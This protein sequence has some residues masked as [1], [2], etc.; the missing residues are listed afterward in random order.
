MTAFNS[1]YSRNH[2]VGKENEGLVIRLRA[3]TYDEKNS[4]LD[5]DITLQNNVIIEPDKTDGTTYDEVTLELGG[6]WKEDK[7]SNVRLMEFSH[8][9]SLTIGGKEED[10]NKA[11][12]DKSKN[13][14]IGTQSVYGKKETGVLSF[15]DIGTLTIN[16]T[17]KAQDGATVRIINC[18]D[19][20]SNKHLSVVGGTFIFDNSN[21]TLAGSH[22]DRSPG[23]KNGAI[24]TENKDSGA[25]NI[26]VRN[27]TFVVEGTSTATDPGLYVNLKTDAEFMITG[28]CT[29]NGV[30]TNANESG[31]NSKT[32]I[33]F[34]NATLDENTK[35]L[36]GDPSQG[37]AALKF[38][39]YNTLDG[40]TVAQTGNRNMTVEAGATV[41]MTNEASISVGGSVNVQNC[42]NISLDNNSSISAGS[43]DNTGSL[44]LSDGATIKLGDM[45]TVRDAETPDS[46]GYLDLTVA[47]SESYRNIT[48]VV[49]AAET[50]TVGNVT[51]QVGQLLYS[52][53]V[54][55]VADTTQPTKTKTVSAADLKKFVGKEV[56]VSIG[57]GTIPAEDRAQMG[58]FTNQVNGV[59]TVDLQGDGGI[60]VTAGGI[61]NYG[62]IQIDLSHTDYPPE[63]LTININGLNNSDGGT[64]TVIGGGGTVVPRS[65]GTQYIQLNV[66]QMQ[67]LYVNGT[68]DWDP[69]NAWNKGK[70]VGSRM[71]YGFNSFKDNPEATDDY[72][73]MTFAG[74][75]DKV[76]YFGG[77]QYNDFSIP[78]DIVRTIKVDTTTYTRCTEKDSGTDYYAWV[79]G[80]AV[81]YTTTL[82]ESDFN[83]ADDNDE[84]AYWNF[85]SIA[86]AGDY[87]Y[88]SGTIM[89]E[90]KTYSRNADKDITVW[91]CCAWQQD[92]GTAVVYTKTETPEGQ[93]YAYT[94]NIEDTN[95]S[96]SSHTNLNSLTLTTLAGTAIIVKPGDAAPVHYIRETAG[97]MK[98]VT[99]NGSVQYYAWK[100][101]TDS[102][103][104]TETLNI[105]TGSSDT[106]FYNYQEVQTPEETIVYYSVVA[107]TPE[108]TVGENVYIRD[109]ADDYQ[110]VR[111]GSTVSYYA[112]KKN[113]DVVYTD[114]ISIK[115]ENDEGSHSYKLYSS[116][117]SF[118][119]DDDD[120]DDST[121]RTI[122]LAGDTARMGALTVGG[123]Q[124]VTLS[125]ATMSQSTG[126]EIANSGTLNVGTGESAKLT[127]SVAKSKVTRD[128]KVR[129]IAANGA[130][131]YQTISVPAET[132]PEKENSTVVVK[133]GSFIVGQPY[134]VEVTDM[135]QCSYEKDKQTNE[136]CIDVAVVKTGARNVKIIV[137]NAQGAKYTYSNYNIQENKSSVKLTNPG[138]G[139]IGIV[140]DDTRFALDYNSETGQLKLK[141]GDEA[142]DLAKD[143]IVRVQ[144]TN[145]TCQ[146]DYSYVVKQ[147]S[148]A[149]RDT[150]DDKVNANFGTGYYYVEVEEASV[151]ESA[152]VPRR[153]FSA[154]KM[155][156]RSA[157]PRSSSST[158]TR[159]T[160]PAGSP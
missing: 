63:A 25:G 128:V 122:E 154:W 36:A 131:E 34:S 58:T 70:N 74:D 71:Y 11:W 144:G 156:E 6:L 84:H 4:Q 139:S 7:P 130:E 57:E 118:S 27:S 138:F 96:V 50:F 53:T 67:T 99:A 80:N 158:S 87:S 32:T 46:K 148:Y 97:D 54:S 123:G 68:W 31:A 1:V 78:G 65:D 113:D 83:K 56:F 2:S 109:S 8:L 108:I 45:L 75:T 61:T 28:T 157:S 52:A 43:F 93:L 124:A 76:V 48:Y 26:I 110:L 35:I 160:W 146:F 14:H 101:G 40:T 102:F 95:K 59:L 86:K 15:V 100:Y 145:G 89:F 13:W 39:G 133:S 51:Y 112:W 5:P 105:K 38:D 82:A 155:R 69:D 12:A 126:K 152:E 66:P 121:T 33:T 142:I 20:T 141:A 136:S 115:S 47:T 159:T 79:N 62:L 107:G 55:V 111:N 72:R 129:I 30:F 24:S 151:S 94:G 9:K 153:R 29:V 114:T 125:G 91:E 103:I 135:H 18:A 104:Y 10:S 23:T 90:G 143:T 21:I 19:V 60:G 85:K 44:V 127:L 41:N 119:K 88:S 42:G 77:S 117:A 134:T 98:W 106:S 81:I 3:G 149:A 22:S 73:S 147:G 150:I 116:V 17:L 37:G 49:R 92:D 137:R 120:D 16:G 140:D 64:V 132:D